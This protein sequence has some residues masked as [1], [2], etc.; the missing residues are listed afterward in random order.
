MTM[1][2]SATL[3]SLFYAHSAARE[4]A[5]LANNI[6]NNKMQRILLSANLAIVDHHHKSMAYMHDIVVSGA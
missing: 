3:P 6:E 1:Q 4:A 2:V 5:I